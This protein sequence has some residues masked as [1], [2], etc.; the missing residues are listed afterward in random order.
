MTEPKLRVIADK[1]CVA[2]KGKFRPVIIIDSEM[3]RIGEDAGSLKDAFELL[4]SAEK[5]SGMPVAIFDDS[6]RQCDLNNVC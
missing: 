4:K 1:E 2:E 6:G 5:G 3:Y